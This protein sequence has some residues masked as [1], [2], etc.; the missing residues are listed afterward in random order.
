MQQES[1]NHQTHQHLDRVRFTFTSAPPVEVEVLRVKKE[2]GAGALRRLIGGED[3]L[4][5]RP[6]MQKDLEA[7]EAVREEYSLYENYGL[8]L[9][10]FSVVK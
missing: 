2:K 9:F 6:S 7:R 1:E 4:K 10:E 8:V 3:L 5:W